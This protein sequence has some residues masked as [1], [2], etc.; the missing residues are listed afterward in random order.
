MWSVNI[1]ILALAWLLLGL[2]SMADAAGPSQMKQLSYIAEIAA[3]DE[4]LPLLKSPK[5]GRLLGKAESAD[6]F[7]LASGWSST[8]DLAAK[9]SMLDTALTVDGGA[10]ASSALS[11]VTLSVDALAAKSRPGDFLHIGSTPK[12]CDS[13]EPFCKQFKRTTTVTQKD[14][15]TFI[16]GQTLAADGVP[17]FAWFRTNP[18]GVTKGWVY[19]KDVDYSFTQL[20]GDKVQALF[21]VRASNPGDRYPNDV[22]RET[23]GASTVKSGPA[24]AAA[25]AATATPAAADC[26]NP[27][28]PQVIKVAITYTARA[29]SE[30]LAEGFDIEE[31]VRTARD[32]S[33]LT[34]SNAD[35]NAQVE[36]VSVSQA[37][38]VEGD[39]TAKDPFDPI[40]DDLLSPHPI[41]WRDLLNARDSSGADIAVAVIDNVDNRNCG[42]SA[43]YRVDAGQAFAAVNWRCMET[44]FSFIHE[45]GHLVGLYHD[46]STRQQYDNVPDSDVQPPYAQGFITGGIHPT[47]SVMAYIT[48]CPSNCGR[49]P[50]WSDP[51]RKNQFGASMGAAD[52]SYETCVWRQRVAVVAN[53]HAMR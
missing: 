8:S 49:W 14:G 39:A 2:A 17:Q 43:G 47:A 44:R 35:I 52:S 51:A 31:Q 19:G 5:T 38:A 41:A 40:L 12:L 22:R 30:A 20:R 37:S 42:Q 46:A 13:D 6:Q 23:A 9:T 45:I 32:I 21:S 34:L 3:G 28:E 1:K 53:F 7:Y 24:A 15:S 26:T 25:A 29:A 18:A 10:N 4:P 11:F 36:L 50:F 27:K 33:N 48:A 16:A